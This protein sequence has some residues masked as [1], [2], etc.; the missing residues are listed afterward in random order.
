MSVHLRSSVRHFAVCELPEPVDAA[1]PAA[2][3][4]ADDVADDVADDAAD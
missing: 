1:V 3:D 2:D 4:A